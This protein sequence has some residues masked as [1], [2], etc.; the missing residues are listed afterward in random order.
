MT[1]SSV[2]ET[3]PA[4]LVPDRV[5]S[6]RYVA[7][8][9]A[10]RQWR[11]GQGWH[12]ECDLARPRRSTGLLCFSVTWHWPEAIPPSDTVGMDSPEYCLL[13]V[14]VG[15]TALVLLVLLSGELVPVVVTNTCVPVA[16]ARLRRVRHRQAADTNRPAAPA[17]MYGE[18]GYHALNSASAS[19]FSKV[20]GPK[21]F[22]VVPLYHLFNTM[23]TSSGSGKQL[24]GRQ[25]R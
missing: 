23:A 17:C 19:R 3:A 12:P 20:R 18:H 4:F 25:D 9:M 10:R 21:L 8:P 24:D 1:S 6:R 2:R 13:S 14:G 11:Y 15:G 5:N 16:M 22:A 7:S